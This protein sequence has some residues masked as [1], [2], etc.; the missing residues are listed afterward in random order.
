MMK[1]Q[2]LL[3]TLL[4]CSLLL[5]SCGGR[6]KN[7][8]VDDQYAINQRAIKDSTT[9]ELI[10]SVYNFGSRKE[11]DKIPFSFRFKNSGTHPLVIIDAHASCGCTRPEKPKK[12]IR[13]GET[14]EIKVIFDS[15]G[16]PGHQEKLIFVDANVKNG[17]PNLKLVGD[18]QKEN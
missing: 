9:V 6:R 11:G 3:I 13:P 4:G 12:P 8:L 14:G 10:D 2:L 7:A 16:K 1:K 15:K 17:F 5:L 18:I